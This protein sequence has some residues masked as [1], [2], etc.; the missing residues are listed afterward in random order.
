MPPLRAVLQHVA[1]TIP[2]VGLAVSPNWGP[3]ASGAA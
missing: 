1:D 2:L 3:A